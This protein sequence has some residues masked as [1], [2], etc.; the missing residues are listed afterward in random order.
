MKTYRYL[1]LVGLAAASLFASQAFATVCPTGTQGAPT[2]VAT[3][4]GD[5][6][7]TDLQTQLNNITTAGPLIDVY[8]GQHA[9]SSY[10]EI[11]STGGSF[12]KIVLE[13]AGNAALNTFGIFDPSDTGNFLQLFSGAASAGWSTLLT[14]TGNTFTA[15]YFDASAVFK[16]QDSI[17]LTGSLFGYYLGA[18][19]ETPTFFSDP[20]KNEAGGTTYPDG[21]PHM[22]AYQG[23]GQ[24]QLNGK[25]FLSNELLLAWEDKPWGQSDL[26]Y[27]D[28][29]VLV[30]SVRSVPEPGVLGMFGLGALMIGLGVAMRR[31]RE[32]V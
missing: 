30:E 16:G 13:I 15:T 11:G 26:D 27:N 1:A 23:N 24:T 3:V 8:N 17:T 19:S 2:C 6:A 7:G 9:P 22:L 21:M 31:R 29:V 20:A 28:F 14:Q 5:G 4:G 32:D 10:W 18:A 12:N 25:T